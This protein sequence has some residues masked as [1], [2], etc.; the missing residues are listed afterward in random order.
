MSFFCASFLSYRLR[1]YRL[2]HLILWFQHM[3]MV[4]IQTKYFLSCF[5]L[6]WWK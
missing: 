6:S 1:F 4:Q 3:A 2:G 5:D